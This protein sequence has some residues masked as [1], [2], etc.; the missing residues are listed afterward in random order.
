M[1]LFKTRHDTWFHLIR[2]TKKI[3][4]CKWVYKIKKNADGTID[5]YKTRLSQKASN[6]N[7]DYK[8]IFSPVVKAT[9]ICL[10]LSIV[11]SRA[12]VFDNSMSRMCFF[13]ASWKRK[14]T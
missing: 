1:L 9:T 7:I 11:V 4:D 14:C 10:V 6:N 2:E 8:D 5:R 3:I 12:G 13:M